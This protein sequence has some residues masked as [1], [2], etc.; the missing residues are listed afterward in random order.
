MGNIIGKIDKYTT[1]TITVNNIEKK[2]V[3]DYDF[4]SKPPSVSLEDFLYNR[5]EYPLIEKEKVVSKNIDISMLLVLVISIIL[6]Y[7]V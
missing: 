4:S 3:K 6:Y 2:L 1:I 7:I 5:T